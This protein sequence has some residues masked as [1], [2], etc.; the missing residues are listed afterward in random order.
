MKQKRV[1]CEACHL[2]G[3][4][5]EYCRWH[6]KTISVIDP[7]GCI[8]RNFYRK[9]G[10][11]VAIGAGIGVVS[12]TAGVAA[13]P[14]VGFKALVGHALAAK[15]TAGGGGAAIAGVNLFRTSTRRRSIDRR[16]KRK[17]VLL[18]L[19]LSRMTVEPN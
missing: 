8:S 1:G 19:Y 7:G 15:M 4:N 3:Y 5:P 2:R 14:V 16:V 18:P 13:A 17:R 11:T 10:K 6:K 9:L 12:A